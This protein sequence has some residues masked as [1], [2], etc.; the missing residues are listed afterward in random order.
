MHISDPSA[1]KII[2]IDASDLGY[3]DILEQNKEKKKEQIFAFVSKHW[4]SAQQ[5]YSTIKKKILP[6]VLC[7]KIPL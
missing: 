1:F 7:P 6:I 4:N 2:K 5:N 3:G